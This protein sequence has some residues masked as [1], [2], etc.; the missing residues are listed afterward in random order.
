MEFV[1]SL[2]FWH[3][4]AL[5]IGLLIAEMIGA[6]GFLLWTGLSAGVVG[7]IV[8]VA[9]QLTWRWQLFL[10]AIMTV[11]VLVLWWRHLQKR[12][13]HSEQPN[14]NQRTSQFVG[15][16]TVLVAPIEHGRGII[17]LDDS[18]WKVS[19]PDLPE[20]TLVEVVGADDNMLL[21]VTPVE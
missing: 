16:K 6:A 11:V 20:G 10:F 5:A 13:D 18:Q 15:R 8:L 3:W 17:R 12:I 21:Q 7:L 1:E 4:F 2:N 19:G 9:P 14:L